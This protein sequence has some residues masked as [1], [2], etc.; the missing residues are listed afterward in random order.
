MI[1]ALFHS[2]ELRWRLELG[3]RGAEGFRQ[4][5]SGWLESLE[6]SAIRKEV[7]AAQTFT[8]VIL[9]INGLA[10]GAAAVGMFQFFVAVLNGVQP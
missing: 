2:G 7:I 4:S 10:V 3:T 1:S 5:L 8:T 6:E 9:L